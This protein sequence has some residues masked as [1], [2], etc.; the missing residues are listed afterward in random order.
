MWLNSLVTFAPK[1]YPAP[2]E[3]TNQFSEILSGSDHIKSQKAP[4]VGI[5]ILRSIVLI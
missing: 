1:K 2:L 3:L 4:V 5:S